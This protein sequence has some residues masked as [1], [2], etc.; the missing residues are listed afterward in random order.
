M[1]VFEQSLALHAQARGKIEPV[2][3][4]TDCHG[5]SLYSTQN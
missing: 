3:V 1:N 4:A 2:I 5:N